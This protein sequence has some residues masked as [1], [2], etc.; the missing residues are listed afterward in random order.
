[1]LNLIDVVKHYSGR[2]IINQLNLSITRG[3]FCVLLGNN[4]E[5]KSTLLQIISGKEVCDSGSITFA[6]ENK[7]V[8][9]TVMQ[10]IHN[11]TIG[12]LTVLEN[13]ALA[14]MRH[15]NA[16][17]RN[18][19]HFQQTVSQLLQDFN[20]EIPAVLHQRVEKLS[21]GQ[22]Q[23]I[24]TLMAIHANPDLLL[25][26]EHTS[27][28]DPLMQLQVMSYTVKEIQKRK[29]TAVMITHCL[30][31]AIRYGDRLL[32]LKNGKIAVDISG[33]QKRQ[34]TI[35]QLKRLFSNAEELQEVENVT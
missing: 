26:D 18:Y 21:G 11:G 17:F 22:R 14:L 4:G 15:R 1:M 29:L 19:G 9:S 35:N 12:E 7:P 27:A 34:L 5:G 3:E 32:I 25:L 8:I 28:L 30:A 33:E 10:N 6:S 13:F 2:K 20:F 23:L 24:A 31:D 16:S